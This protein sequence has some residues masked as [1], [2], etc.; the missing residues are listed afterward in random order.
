MKEF[1]YAQ[2]T[3]DPLSLHDLYRVFNNYRVWKNIIGLLMML[4]KTRLPEYKILEP[5]C[6]GGDRLRFFTNLRV[7]PENCFGFDISE[8]AIGICKSLSPV[9]MNFQVGSILDIP[10]EDNKFDI[11]F[12]SNVLGC[13]NADNDVVKISRELRRV[14]K[15]DGVLL[16]IDMNELYF[17]YYKDSKVVMDKELRCFDTSKSELEGLLTGEFT[18]FRRVNVF[19][20]ELYVMQDGSY[21]DIN[22]LPLI[23]NGIDQ[24]T[25]PCVYTLYAFVTNDVCSLVTNK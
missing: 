10:H 11:I 18:Q 4:G 21:A 15:K 5:G 16:I 9:S 23:D 2:G 20:G 25:V 19:R 22:H 1:L 7:R 14:I 12:C 8:K 6:A 3:T 24:G 17:Q 13:F